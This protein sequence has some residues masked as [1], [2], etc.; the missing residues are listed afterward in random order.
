MTTPRI[1]GAG[2]L[3][4][5]LVG[6]GLAATI[7]VQQLGAALPAVLVPP[8]TLDQPTGAGWT[9]TWR[10][11]AVAATPDQLLAWQQLDQLVDGVAGVLP[12]ERAEPVS[13][14]AV[15][16]SDPLPAYALTFTSYVD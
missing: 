6:A 8:P 1:A 11:L 3:A 14:A 13:F 5:Q 15:P 12:I 9:A 4:A 10:L 7:D 16:G 2:Q